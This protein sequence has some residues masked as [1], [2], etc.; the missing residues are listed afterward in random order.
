MRARVAFLS[1]TRTTGNWLTDWPL[2]QRNGAMVD[3]FFLQS[4][5]SS[6]GGMGLSF[7]TLDTANIYLPSLGRFISS[8]TPPRPLFL[9]LDAL[10][11]RTLYKPQPVSLL[12]V[13]P[14][15]LYRLTTAVSYFDPIGILAMR[16]VFPCK[17]P[18][19]P[20]LWPCPLLLILRSPVV[21]FGS[22]HVDATY[23]RIRTPSQSLAQVDAPTT[24]T[25]I[26][27]P[28]SCSDPAR[29]IMHSSALCLQSCLCL[30]FFAFPRI[31]CPVTV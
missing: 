8:R 30:L 20:R 22:C 21:A 19:H 9:A 27:I 15:H 17:T 10:H 3:G 14:L 4:F 16:S 1:Q 28:R 23:A 11:T 12:L 2:P 13:L 5:S 18:S 26:V 24:A 25:A 6:T 31:R 7:P 29:R